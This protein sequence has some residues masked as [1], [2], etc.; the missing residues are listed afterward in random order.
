MVDFYAG[1]HSI[2]GKSVFF[3]SVIASVSDSGTL[4]LRDRACQFLTFQ[5][6]AMPEDVFRVTH[7]SEFEINSLSGVQVQDILPAGTDPFGRNG[8]ELADE[9]LETAREVKT[10]D[11]IPDGLKNMQVEVLQ[12]C[13]NKQKNS[14]FHEV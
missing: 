3:L 8:H 12:Y 9:A 5:K 7:T 10:L 14:V 11:T 2:G 4:I 1:G 6:K 13:R